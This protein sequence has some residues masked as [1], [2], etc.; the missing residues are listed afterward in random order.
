MPDTLRITDKRND[1]S[2]EQAF[3]GE[4]LRVG[5]ASSNDIRLDRVGVSRRHCRIERRNEEVFV[6]DLGSRN[7][8]FLD[9]TR[10]EPDDPT[11][12]APGQV[13]QVAEFLL[14]LEEEETP[15]PPP[16]RIPRP[17]A[18]PGGER[19]T[20]ARLK[21]EVRERL[22]ERMDLKHRDMTETG[23]AEL[24]AEAERVCARCVQEVEGL[25]PAWL[26]PEQLLKEVVDEAVGLGP[27]E[28]LIADETVTEIMVVGWDRIYIERAGRLHR[29]DRRFT[30]DPQVVETIRRILAPLGRRIDET[31][32]MADGRLPDGSRVN[33]IIAPLAISG[34]CLTIRKFARTPYTAADLIRFGTLTQR[35]VDFLALAVRHRADILISGGT[36]TG[37]TT[38]LNVVSDFIP[39]EERIVTIE[40]AAELQLSQ[41]H[42]V[43]L[44]SR[45]PNLEGKNAIRIRDLVRNALRMR[46][47]RIVV[48]EV[49]GGE[50]L[51]MLQAMN[52]GHDGS[53]T[54]LHANSPRDA[55]NRLETLV[56]MAG[57]DL[58]SRAIR[59]QVASAIDLIVQIGRLPD[60]SRRVLSVQA[61]PGIEEDRIRLEEIYRFEQTAL[62]PGG[63]VTGRFAATGTE[64][65]FVEILRRS[66]VPVDPE[67]FRPEAD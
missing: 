11:L 64:P 31:T 36:G 20:P 43:R 28:D 56:L 7:G 21:R 62:G 19:V 4:A 37:K 51:D 41:E 10:L 44:E 66:G 8:T 40:D 60:G 50:A 12:F 29:T 53:L 42:L 14:R 54:T 61:V 33:A 59:E 45:P 55:L 22:V 25:L 13:L 35:M 49:R 65:P 15:A 9:G 2:W 24:R 16:Q 38:L 39:R 26:A 34:P 17:E 1:E 30:D 46:P 47:D 63:E 5:K 23:P 67:L 52:T 3:D 58:P 18:E 48:G 57:L 27:L 32:P 6:T